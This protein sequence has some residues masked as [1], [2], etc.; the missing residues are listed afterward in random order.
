VVLKTL[1]LDKAIAIQRLNPSYESMT[2]SAIPFTLSLEITLYVES[3]SFRP[4]LWT[5]E[6]EEQY[7]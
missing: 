2:I 4:F 6:F 5:A 3:L 1:Y 7:E